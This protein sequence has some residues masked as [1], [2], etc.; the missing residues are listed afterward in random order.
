MTPDNDPTTREDKIEETEQVLVTLTTPNIQITELVQ[1]TQTVAGD[2]PATNLHTFPQVERSKDSPEVDQFHQVINEGFNIPSAISPDTYSIS[3]NLHLKDFYEGNGNTRDIGIAL[4]SRGMYEDSTILIIDED[5]LPKT[6]NIF[7]GKPVYLRYSHDDFGII[8]P[9]LS[10]TKGDGEKKKKYLQRDKEGEIKIYRDRLGNPITDELGN[11]IPIYKSKSLDYALRINGRVGDLKR[12]QEYFAT[13]FNH[14]ER[15]SYDGHSV[16]KHSFDSIIALKQLLTESQFKCKTS[17]CKVEREVREDERGKPEGLRHSFVLSANEV[18]TL[19]GQFQPEKLVHAEVARELANS[20]K[21]RIDTGDEKE[22]KK[23]GRNLRVWIKEF[24]GD[25]PMLAIALYNEVKYYLKYDYN[26]DYNTERKYSSKDIDTFLA[27]EDIKEILGENHGYKEQ[28]EK[29]GEIFRYEKAEGASS[30]FGELLTL[31][32]KVDEMIR[33]FKKRDVDSRSL[34]YLRLSAGF[35]R[36]VRPVVVLKGRVINERPFPTTSITTS[37]L[38]EYF[39]NQFVGDFE[40]YCVSKNPTEFV[41][42]SARKGRE[43]LDDTLICIGENNNMIKNIRLLDED[44]VTVL[45]KQ[46]P[47]FLEMDSEVVERFA[48]AASVKR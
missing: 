23:I 26:L 17:Y 34:E 19:P 29:V 20:V 27:D 2:T 14:P 3:R 11:P 1:E 6:N 32:S 4:K 16:Y 24:A 28:V 10:H 15:I 8:K 48:K 18:I 41:L 31:E 21:G 47:E 33:Y 44:W 45:S 13:Y 7:N 12:L 43:F 35:D 36:T 46:F 42:P 25:Q 5:N 39:S 30:S 40:K 22:G 38:K 37:Y 9:E